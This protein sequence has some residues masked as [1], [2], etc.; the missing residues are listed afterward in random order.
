MRKSQLF[1]NLLFWAIAPVVFGQA[2]QEPSEFFSKADAFFENNIKNGKVAYA[3]IKDDP[4]M[5]DELIQMA[6]GIGVSQENVKEY[7]QL[8][9]LYHDHKISAVLQEDS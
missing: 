1:F 3:D 8:K 6:Q 2:G 5:L 7:Q 9:H 4:A